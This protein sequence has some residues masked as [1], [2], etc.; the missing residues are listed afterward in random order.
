MLQ[1]NNNL[2]NYYSPK[3]GEEYPENKMVD[4]TEF[5][6]KYTD[7]HEQEEQCF[8]NKMMNNNNNIK[9]QLTPPSLIKIDLTATRCNVSNKSNMSNSSS[10]M[11]SPYSPFTND[12][13]LSIEYH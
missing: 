12:E 8:N 2:T 11:D 6:A 3:H 13:V 9:R 7:E 5:C 1:I 10:I 4:N